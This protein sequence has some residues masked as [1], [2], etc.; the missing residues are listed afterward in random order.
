MTELVSYPQNVI[1]SG[2][3]ELC[4]IVPTVTTWRA[5]AHVTEFVFFVNQ[6]TRSGCARMDSITAEIAERRVICGQTVDKT[7][8]KA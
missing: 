3:I 5:T 1:Q 2:R 8:K 6:M 4:S 7:N